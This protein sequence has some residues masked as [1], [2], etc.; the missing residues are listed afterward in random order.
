MKTLMK[1][2][3]AST[4]MT[5]FLVVHFNSYSQDFEIIFGKE[6]I[7]KD[8]TPGSKGKD[9]PI[10]WFNVNTR[11]DTWSKKK[12]MLICIGIPNGVIR[13]EKQ[14]ENFILHI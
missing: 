10:K 9:Q 14:Y 11:E 8:I 4:I 3:I 13:T 2:F 6:V 7:L 12:G 1:V 5:I